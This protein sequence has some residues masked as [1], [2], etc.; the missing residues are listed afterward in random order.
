MLSVAGRGNKNVQLMKSLESVAASVSVLVFFLVSPPAPAAAQLAISSNR[1]PPGSEGGGSVVPQAPQPSQA[2]TTGVFCIEEMTATFCNV[3]TGPNINGT[4]RAPDRHR[5]AQPAATHRRYRPARHIRRSTNYATEETI[6][7]PG[8]D[9]TR[10]FFR[11]RAAMRMTAEKSE[12]AAI[13]SITDVPSCRA[14]LAVYL[15][16]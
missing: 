3:V 10:A 16:R 12:R 2:P 5:T 13:S 7:P 14:G 4:A 9:S 11:G 6:K 8:L 15:V 1:L